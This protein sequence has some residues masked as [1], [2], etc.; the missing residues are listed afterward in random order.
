MAQG[1]DRFRYE[2]LQ[3]ARYI[4]D[5]LKSI[6]KGIASGMLSFSDEDGEIVM[7]PKGLLNLKLTATKEDDQ[8]RITVRVTWQD[9]GKNIKKRKM[10][11]VNA[12][13]KKK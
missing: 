2:S 6:T 11:S 3:D 9:E 5:V 8:R 4:Q 10:L 7:E 1:K 12:S 13:P